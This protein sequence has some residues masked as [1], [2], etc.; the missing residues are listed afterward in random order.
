VEADIPMATDVPRVDITGLLSDAASGDEAASGQVWSALYSELRRLARIKLDRER[1]DHTLSPTALVH[2]AYLKLVDGAVASS[3]NRHHF[4]AVAARAMRQI[5][6]DH[7]RKRARI[8]RGDRRPLLQLDDGRD[9]PLDPDRDPDLVLAID[10]A[11]GRLAVE[12]ERMARVVELRFFGGLTP[13]ETAEVL[14]VTRR[15]VERD[16]SLAR[17]YLY[18]QLASDGSGPAP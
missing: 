17:A 3:A 9:R 8:K 13:V 15:T 4:L 5:L 6:V 14:D 1:P 11:L 12:R 7:A 18:R 2:E 16:W 10:E